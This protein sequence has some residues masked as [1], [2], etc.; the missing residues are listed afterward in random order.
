VRTSVLFLSV[1]SV[2]AVLTPSARADQLTLKNGDRLTGIIVKSDAKTVLIK[3]EFAGDVNV[4]WDAVSSMVSS[5]P[6]HLLLRDGQTVVGTVTTTDGKLNV[7][8]KAAGE[9][10]APKDTVIEVRNDDEQKAH[11]AEVDRLRNPRLTDF[12]SGLLDTGLS[13][14]RGNSATLAYNLSAKAVR[15]TTRDKITVYSTAVYANDD[16]TP[17]NRTTAHAIRGGLRGDF[18]VSERL[19]VF[20]FTDFEYDQFQDLD[21]RNVLGGGLGYH[22]IKAKSTTFDVFGGG[23]YEQEFFSAIPAFPTGLT[24]KTGEIVAGEEFDAKLN[25]RTT[26]AE[27]FSLYPNVSNTGEYRFQF[28]ATAA[29]K[30]KTWLSWQVTYSDRYL[31]DPL[32]GLKKNDVLLSTG[33]RLSFGKGAL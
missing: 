8:T 22:V 32:P 25:G 19:F 28:D 26:L 7:A 2:L 10:T 1:L 21:L 18:N 11:D 6:L 5:Q 27:K 12:W 24:R 23:D 29:T 13:V 9:I 16:T 30:L 14:T 15:A 3:T 33:L 20:G 17:P 4:Q 31:S